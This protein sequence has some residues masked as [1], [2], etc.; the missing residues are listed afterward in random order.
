VD[1]SI[2]GQ[3]PLNILGPLSAPAFTET[4]VGTPFPDSTRYQWIFASDPSKVLQFTARA[5]FTPNPGYRV[6]GRSD[7]APDNC[8]NAPAIDIEPPATVTPSTPIPPNITVTVP[9]FGPVTVTV[10][11]DDDGDTI[12]CVDELDTCFTVNVG[13]DR[14]GPSDPAPPP[15]GDVGSPGASEATGIGGEAEGEAPEGEVLVGLALDLVSAPPSPK[16]FA[17][18]VYRGAAYV[19]M[20]TDAGLDMD[21]AGSMLKDGS[22]IFAEK[23]NLTKWAVTANPGYNWSVTPFYREAE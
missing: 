15:P 1:L 14:G 17:P 11:A 12:F 9:G 8:G 4:V 6:A 5:S 22:F 2:G 18:G 19:F 3:T 10:D 16:L 7:A 20:G 21:Y 23:D 13:S